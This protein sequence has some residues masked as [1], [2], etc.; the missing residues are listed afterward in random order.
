MAFAVEKI[1]KE[2]ATLLLIVFLITCDS[3]HFTGARIL[4]VV[5]EQ[6]N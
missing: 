4:H 5:N 1:F 6:V 2:K 3:D